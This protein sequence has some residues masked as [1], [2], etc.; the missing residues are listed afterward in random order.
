MG[1]HLKRLISYSE[2]EE[3]ERKEEKEDEKEDL[4]FLELS[5]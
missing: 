2:E 4:W 1:S 3:T 5:A